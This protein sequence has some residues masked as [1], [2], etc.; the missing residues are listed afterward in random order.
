MNSE[1]E[2][3]VDMGEIFLLDKAKVISRAA[4]LTHTPTVIVILAGS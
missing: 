3:V 2:L 1:V 4:E